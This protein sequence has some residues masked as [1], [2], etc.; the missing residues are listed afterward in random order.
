MWRLLE[1]AKRC[2]L[3]LICKRW[4]EL[5]ILDILLHRLL[6][7]ECL[8]LS[9]HR[10]AYLPHAMHQ[11]TLDLVPRLTLREIVVRS[12]HPAKHASY[13]SGLCRSTFRTSTSLRSSLRSLL[14]FS[15]HYWLKDSKQFLLPLAE[16]HPQHL[17]ECEWYPHGLCNLESLDA[18]HR[19][20]HILLPGVLDE[21]R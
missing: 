1:L 15:I 13:S 17:G 16:A 11:L 6:A 5:A 9:S 21:L 7:I 12:S 19:L 2:H 10:P 8:V 18:P 14:G 20:Q 3:R 4:G